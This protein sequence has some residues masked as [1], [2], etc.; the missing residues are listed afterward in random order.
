MHEVSN[1][2]LTKPFPKIE[3]NFID[4]DK[5]QNFPKTPKVKSQKMKCMMKKGIK[6][7]ISEEKQDQ[8]RR[9]LRNEVFSE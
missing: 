9:T 1:I 2:I 5:S 6:D 7:L 8:G 4:F 3:Q